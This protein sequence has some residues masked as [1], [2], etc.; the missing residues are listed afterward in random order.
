MNMILSSGASLELGK[1]LRGRNYELM[2]NRLNSRTDF[3]HLL[4]GNLS[5]GR[6]KIVW[7]PGWGRIKW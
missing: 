5:E 3:V 7:N 4:K 1:L 6:Y 2:R